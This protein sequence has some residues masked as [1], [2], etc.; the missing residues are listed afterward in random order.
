M[1]HFNQFVLESKYDLFSDTLAIELLNFIKTGKVQKQLTKSLDLPGF[2]YFVLDATV[3]RSK[4][5]DPRLSSS[6]QFLPWEE[7]NFK[8]VGFSVD[9]N[10]IISKR[11][12]A[13]FEIKMKL[14]VLLN[15]ESEPNCYTNLY[16][17]LLDTIRHELEHI[18]QRVDS[19]N[20]RGYFDRLDKIRRDFESSY[21]Y[22]LLPD[23]V[24]AM[25]SGMK[26][27]ASKR[28]VP[29]DLE[30]ESYLKPMV[31]YGFISKF[32]FYTV[33][34]TWLSFAISTFPNI[35][36]SKKYSNINAN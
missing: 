2:P 11:R 16:L 21:K 30:F 20:H 26:L 13:N 28:G 6:F 8:K 23:E 27:S 14:S 17:K 34:K 3:T 31:S 19:N 15:P 35:T 22:F 9:S 29:L 4:E 36:I 18:S 5:F 24:P 10:S 33:M 32:E 12:S 1:K 25:V 7:L